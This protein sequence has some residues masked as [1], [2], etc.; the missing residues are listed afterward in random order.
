MT[1]PNG[2]LRYPVKSEGEGRHSLAR[3]VFPV[4]VGVS[5]VLPEGEEDQP[6]ALN[7]VINIVVLWN[8][9]YMTAS[10]EQRK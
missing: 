7:L 6:D 8:T 10:L 5:P 2:A 9:I 1:S 4:S 3:A